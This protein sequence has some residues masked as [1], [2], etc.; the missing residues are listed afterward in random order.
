MIPVDNP[1]LFQDLD[2][3]LTMLKSLINPETAN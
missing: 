1:E 2:N 3:Q